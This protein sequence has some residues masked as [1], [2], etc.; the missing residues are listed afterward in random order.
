MDI[1]QGIFQSLDFVSSAA[2]RN[3]RYKYCKKNKGKWSLISECNYN[4]NT[5]SKTKSK[6]SKKG[7]TRRK[8]NIQ[9]KKK[10]N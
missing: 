4:K 8:S 3:D 2:L 1:I 5:K 7:G 6:V 10:I 9:K